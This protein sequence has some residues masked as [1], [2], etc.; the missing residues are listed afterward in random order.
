[1]ARFMVGEITRVTALGRN[2]VDAVYDKYGDISISILTLEFENGA[3]GSHSEFT[4][5]PSRV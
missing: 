1:M 2:P 5:H 3:S 4:T